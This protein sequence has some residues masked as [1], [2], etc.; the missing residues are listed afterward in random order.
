MPE[1]LTHSVSSSVTVKSVP[2]EPAVTDTVSPFPHATP[3]GWDGNTAPIRPGIF[4]PVPALADA[5]ADLLEL[6]PP[7]PAADVAAVAFPVDAV[8]DIVGGALPVGEEHPVSAIIPRA[9]LATRATV[10]LG[11]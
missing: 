3:C 4:C 6:L 1:K 10:I 2:E 5:E 9:R 8:A 7:G 11:H